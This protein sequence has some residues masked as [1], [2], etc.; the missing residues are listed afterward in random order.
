MILS[1]IIFII[2]FI[3][4]IEISINY[5]NSGLLCVGKKKRFILKNKLNK[6]NM[7]K[8]KIVKTLRLYI[9]CIRIEIS[10]NCIGEGCRDVDYERRR[11]K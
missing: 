1:D 4:E 9:W 7:S 10:R 3:L 6:L 11:L 8:I 2:Y 5:I